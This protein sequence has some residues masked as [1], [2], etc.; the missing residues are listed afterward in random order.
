MVTEHAIH[1]GPTCCP[2]PRYPDD[3][4][5][6]DLREL[7]YVGYY[8]IFILLSS[9]DLIFTGTILAMGGV[10]LNWLAD[11]VISTGGVTGMVLFKFALVTLVIVMIENI[12]RIRD[13][14]GQRIAKLAILITTFPVVVGLAQILVETLIGFHNIGIR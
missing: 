7:R 4:V 10:E 11:Q 9:L 14:V 8:L 2:W 1:Y 6:P 13:E 5:E 12:G 3:I